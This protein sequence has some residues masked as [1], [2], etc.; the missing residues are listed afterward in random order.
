MKIKK[1]TA[2]IL[3][4]ILTLGTFTFALAATDDYTPIYTAEDL[5]NIRNDLDGKY[6]LMNDIDLSVYE[7]WEPIGSSET[8]FTGELDGDKYLIKN[9]KI[10]QKEN[11]CAGVFAYCQNSSIKNISII[12]CNIQTDSE[13]ITAGIIAAIIKNSEISNCIVS[14][15]IN[16]NSSDRI[17]VGGII[18]A[19]SENSIISRCKNLSNISACMEYTNAISIYN[20]C[21]GGI[22]GS[23]YATISECSNYGNIETIASGKKN[24]Y[25]AAVQTGGIA[26]ITFGEILNCYNVADI[27]ASGQSKKTMLGGITGY[28]MPAKDL[29]SV[30]SVGNIYCNES[31]AYIGSIAGYLD[32]FFTSDETVGNVIVANCYFVESTNAFGFDNS[33]YKENII[34][35]SENKFNDQNNFIGFDFE[36]IWKME[37]N[38]YPILQ[39]QPTLPD[40]DSGIPFDYTPIYTAEDLNNIRNDLDGKYILMNDIDLSTYENWEPIGSSET[41]FTGELDGN[42]YSISNLTINVYPTAKAT[43][44]YGLFAYASDIIIKSINLINCDINVTHIGEA[45]GNCYLGSIAGYCYGAEISDCVVSGKICANGFRVAVAGGILGRTKTCEIS[46]CHNYADVAFKN[47]SYATDVIIGGIIGDLTTESTISESSNHGSVSI[48]DGIKKPNGYV[49]IGGI[50]GNCDEMWASENTVINCY[51]KG[52]VS[53][54]SASS[55]IKIGGICGESYETQCVY[56]VG[57]IIVPEGFEGLAGAISGNISQ[58]NLA[59]G[60]PH[61]MT[62]AYYINDDMIPSYDWEALPDSFEEIPFVNVKLLTDEEFKKQESF[63]GFDFENIWKMEEN[64]YPVLRNQPKIVAEKISVEL[65]AGKNC[66]SKTPHCSNWTTSD[67]SVAIIDENGIIYAQESGEAIISVE[68]PY[69]YITEYRVTVTGD[70]DFVDTPTPDPEPENSVESAEIVYVPLKNKL[71]FSYGSPASPDG[72]VL[73]LKFKDG[74]ESTETIRETEYGMLAGRQLI[75]GVGHTAEVRFGIQ[76]ETLYINDESVSVEYSYLAIPPIRYVV[77]MVIDLCFGFLLPPI[78]IY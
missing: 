12:N 54:D 10:I 56:N 45:R 77:Y 20:Y 11:V 73:K 76:H 24:L 27:T 26:G 42:G 44:Y 39:N 31:N 43:H 18:G 23:S 47:L 7:N 61:Y 55:Y 71:V 28:R 25:L 74:T 49:E 21:V 30:Y 2:I 34:G 63:V 13:R 3:T 1:I 37:E 67:P 4:F 15:T 33:E 41:P 69:G 48:T 17:I 64:G 8:P 66:A 53:T 72:I 52:S 40:D 51:N 19:A 9:L 16:V 5:N 57:K 70:S 50:C 36:N 35:L 32:D 60:M 6:I 65:E 14:G 75:F 38:G 58:S 22:V 68:Y 29:I 78:E 46:N 59:I 62:N